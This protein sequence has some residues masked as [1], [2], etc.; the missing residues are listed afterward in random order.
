MTHFIEK[1]E[2]GKVLSQCRCPSVEK[3]ERVVGPCTHGEIGYEAPQDELQVPE[4]ETGAAPAE[5]KLEV[6]VATE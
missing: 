4:P 1:C 2:C 6:E 5:P 3:S